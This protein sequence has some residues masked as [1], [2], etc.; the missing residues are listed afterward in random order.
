M[1]PAP[2]PVVIP[3]FLST[4]VH[5]YA[6]KGLTI[7]FTALIG[8]G[9][10]LAPNEQVQ[11]TTLVLGAVGALASLAWTYLYSKF[12]TVRLA[13]A[14]NAGPPPVPVPALPQAP[15]VV[16]PANANAPAPGAA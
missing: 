14:A 16:E 12:A 2:Q 3:T 10:K 15:V 6:Q 9:L 13:A 4:L 11:I 8:Y 5:N 7:A 1:N